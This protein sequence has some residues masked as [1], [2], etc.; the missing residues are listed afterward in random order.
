MTRITA[1]CLC[2][3]IVVFTR[4]A[5]AETFTFTAHADTTSAIAVPNSS[6]RPTT[7]VNQKGVIE[8]IS[9]KGKKSGAD[10]IV[11]TLVTNEAQ[12]PGRG[13]FQATERTG[14]SYGGSFACEYTDS[15]LTSGNCWGRFVGKTGSYKGRVGTASW[16]FT[17]KDTKDTTVGVGQ[18]ND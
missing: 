1:V 13:V 3:A 2:V 12:L 5:S 9:G 8:L 17:I 4:V 6:G 14:D 7:A 16:H 10:I 11:T 15:A 18:W